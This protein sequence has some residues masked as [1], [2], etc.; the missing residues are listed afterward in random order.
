MKKPCLVVFLSTLIIFINYT[1]FLYAGEVPCPDLHPVYFSTE[2]DTM[3]D[4]VSHIVRMI[5]KDPFSCDEKANISIRDVSKS[6][7]K[8]KKLLFLFSR[9]NRELT[10]KIP[11]YRIDKTKAVNFSLFGARIYKG[12]MGFKVYYVS[13]ENFVNEQLINPMKKG[14]QMRIR[15][16]TFSGTEEVVFSLKDFSKAFQ[17]LIPGGQTY[18]KQPAKKK[19]SSPALKQD[20]IKKPESETTIP[21]PGMI[22]EEDIQ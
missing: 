12:N 13:E 17:K 20:L 3:A 22:I 9:M 15:Y 21:K 10:E 16:Y 11:I 8:A 19:T 1:N 7:E 6:T 14:H 5:G 4:K 18:D 2:K